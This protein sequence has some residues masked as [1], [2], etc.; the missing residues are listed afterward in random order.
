MKIIYIFLLVS[1]LCYGQN[2]TL[3]FQEIDEENSNSCLFLMPKGNF[4]YS[5]LANKSCRL[6]YDLEG[7][8]IINNN[9][10]TITY[11]IEWEVAEGKPLSNYVVFV[12]KDKNNYPLPNIQ[13]DFYKSS[14]NKISILSD[15]KGRAIIYLDKNNTTF[16]IDFKTKKLKIKATKSK[17][18]IEITEQDNTQK[19]FLISNSLSKEILP[20]KGMLI[21]NVIFLMRDGKLY[22]QETIFKGH[23]YNKLLKNW[24]WNNF[25]KN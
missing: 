4:V 21:P 2:D 10:I 14:K 8:W 22:Y 20:T 17:N 25:K 5:N 6:W 19:N 1:N 24:K 18:Y 3:K 9:K 16:F 7:N 11:P 12:L 23:Y 13:I 15:E